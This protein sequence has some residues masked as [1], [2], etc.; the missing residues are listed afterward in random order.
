MLSVLTTGEATLAAG[1]PRSDVLPL[2]RDDI[3]RTVSDTALTRQCLC[4]QP[5]TRNLLRLER[6]APHLPGR[7]AA[8]AGVPIAL[9]VVAVRVE[10]EL[11]DPDDPT[12]TGN[13]RF[14]LRDTAAYREAH[15]HNFDSAPH[16][17]RYFETHLRALNLY[18]NTVSNGEVSLDYTVFPY[19]SDS[20]YQLAHPMAY[21][22]RQRGG[23][24]GVVWGLEQFIIDAA[25]V[26]AAD[27]ALQF[28]DY[29]AVIFFHPGADRQGDFLRDTPNNL[30]TAFVRLGQSISFTAGVQDELTEAI[31]MPETMIQDGRITVLNAVLAHEFG[32]QLGLVDLYNTRS[33]LTQVGNFSLMDNNAADVGVDVEV[34]GRRRIL[35]GALPVFPDAWS[36]L[37]LGFVSAR[38]VIAGSGIIVPDAENLNILPQT[39]PQVV[40]VPISQTEY[41]LIEHRRFDSD[42]KGDAGLRLDSVTNVVLEPVDTI[43]VFANREYDFLLPGN[44][45]LI[46]HVDEGVAA[47]DYVTSDD[48][49]NNFQ[50]NTLQ[51]D[52]SRR[53]VRL[54]EA[55]GLVNFG[56]FYSAGTGTFRDYFYDPNNTELSPTT[57]PPATSN[58]GAKTN[59]RVHNITPPLN[60]MRVDISRT[61]VLTNFPVYTGHAEARISAPVMEDLNPT[62]GNQW[63]YPGDG[64]P[65]VFTAHRHYILGWDWLANPIRGVPVADT[66]TSFD[67]SL[68]VRT[69]RPLA[70]GDPGEK[71][72]S[73]PIL[74]DI[75]APTGALI[76]VTTAGKIYV[77]NTADTDND[78]LFDLRFTAQTAA[79]PTG[80]PVV[81]FR[82]G[83]VKELAV[84]VGS[85]AVELLG[86]LSADKSS[87]T[88]AATGPIR[89]IA[90]LR[91]EAA[92]A[93]F[94]NDHW[95]VASL[96]SNGPATL[97]SS[98]PLYGP[99]MGDLDRD[100]AYDAVVIDE[101]GRLWVLDTLLQPLPGF[102][103][104]TRV[105]PSGPPSL[106]DVD[107]D[108]Y[109]DIL[110]AG[111]GMLF[112]YAHNG[113]LLPNFPAT[114]G[115]RSAPDSAAHEPIAAD[116]NLGGQ[117]T[118]MTAGSRRAVFAFDGNGTPNPEFPLPLGDS[119]TAA[120]A[121]APNPA[122]NH[123]AIFAR[124]ADGFLYAYELSSA[125]GEVAALWPMSA[126][127]SR[128][129][130]TIP[131][132]DLGPLGDPGDF[133][134]TERAFVYP[135]PANGYAVVR[136][137]LGED[138][139]VRIR[140]FD[141]TGN[142]IIESPGPGQGGL[143]NEWTWDC[144]SAASGVYFA[145]IE[146][147]GKGNGRRETV[148]CKMAVVQ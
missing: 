30:F 89:G 86:L 8:G 24:S 87:I 12:T 103:L 75:A 140:I 6:K 80:P 123:S 132:E 109:L 23:D 20:A 70:M 90:G 2:R 130:A 135:N 134:V 115:R 1:G 25:T 104:D 5:S 106:A 122:L 105:R 110:V 32:H 29:D 121:W 76:A 77:W 55:D 68:V 39:V 66:T 81:L 11:E 98:E 26:A 40:K 83:T 41:Y 113:V 92:V 67:T 147:H 48:I 58:T 64:R 88:T 108:G 54:V 85:G 35:F 7:R 43:G 124:A 28:S 63:R 91:R 59:I 112:A 96:E 53:F 38:E 129:T 133:F 119:A 82:G 31:I 3:V 14:D 47:L 21:Y 57:N 138:A 131:I 84:P 9:R 97:L 50:A 141:L 52:Y 128:R 65:E 62:P 139:D 27:P 33:F 74:A 61:G 148:L 136:Y 107:G 60:P 10:F 127:D 126:H 16:N 37:Y 79:A 42:G 45:L 72:L 13:G 144:A 93:T 15:G 142:L 36:R 117:L 4:T 22:G 51:W 116:L 143:Y 95:G 114:L 111:E 118:L 101:S 99:V 125:S 17:K 120:V 44:G 46:W 49:P 19:A 69:I 34:D 78:G 100:S 145:H 94:Q 73:P 18:W 71:W 137:W 56:G 146:V 102:P